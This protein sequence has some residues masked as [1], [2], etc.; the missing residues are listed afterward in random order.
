MALMGDDDLEMLGSIDLPYCKS[1]VTDDLL[2]SGMGV[3]IQKHFTAFPWLRKI[4][5]DRAYN[6]NLLLERSDF[7]ALPYFHHKFITKLARDFRARDK[8][9]KD[10]ERTGISA[11][12]LA[13]CM[14][15]LRVKSRRSANQVLLSSGR[16]SSLPKSLLRAVQGDQ[17]TDNSL[18]GLVME[19][20]G[21]GKRSSLLA[22]KE[23]ERKLTRITSEAAPI[24]IWGSG[25]H[26]SVLMELV[27]M[28]GR[29]FEMPTGSAVFTSG[30]HNDCDNY[31]KIASFLQRIEQFFHI[32][33]TMVYDFYE[34]PGLGFPLISCSHHRYHIPSFFEVITRDIV[35]LAPLPENE[36]G[37]IQV[38]SAFDLQV[39]NHS[40][41]TD[42]IGYVYQESCQCGLDTK[43]LQFKNGLRSRKFPLEQALMGEN[44]LEAVG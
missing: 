25:K 2:V 17:Y 9:N 38:L 14:A 27:G 21:V 16:K 42:D 4:Y 8:S 23:L 35:T 12:M 37:L 44:D 34:I 5:A 15:Q 32:P 29:E 22:A 11:K 6:P 18:Q 1:R 7:A 10:L 43:I 41:L 26:A 24:A 40:I 36:T 39:P 30:L 13:N 20:P 3:L 31:S 33:R 19:I 28:V